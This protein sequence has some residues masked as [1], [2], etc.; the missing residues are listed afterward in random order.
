MNSPEACKKRLLKYLIPVVIFSFV[1]N[2]PK[3]LEAQIVWRNTTQVFN[4][5]A[6]VGDQTI[7]LEN[8]TILVP[9]VSKSNM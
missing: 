9:K 6:S 8:E 1:F 2:I 5:T 7:S 3:F 4:Y